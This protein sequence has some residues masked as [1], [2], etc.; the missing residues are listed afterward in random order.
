VAIF[1]HNVVAK[2]VKLISKNDNFLVLSVG[3]CL[4]CNVYLPCADDDKF[5][6]ILASISNIVSKNACYDKLIIAGDFNMVFNVVHPRWEILSEFIAQTNTSITDQFIDPCS[7]P[8]YSYIHESLGQ[9]SFIDHFLTSLN[10]ISSVATISIADSGC[11]LSDHCAIIMSIKSDLFISQRSVDFL[12]SKHCNDI[13]RIRWDKGN[14]DLYY[15]RTRCLL[16]GS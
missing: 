11:N 13:K 8:V 16:E 14:L 4:L 2:H 5:V 1:V 9:R 6:D 10:L 7:A 15:N 12:N 3:S